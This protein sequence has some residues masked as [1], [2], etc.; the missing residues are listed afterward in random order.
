MKLKF[1]ISQKLI[2]GFGLILVVVL[3]NSILTIVTLVRSTNLNNQVTGIYGPTVNELGEMDMMITQSK[4]LIRNWVFVDKQPGTPDKIRLAELHRTDWPT[5]KQSLQPIAKKWESSE[6]LA[7]IENVF[8]QTD[9]LF[10]LHQY[11]MQNLSSFDS[12]EDVMVFFEAEDMVVEGGGIITLSDQIV[13]KLSQLTQKYSQKNERALDQMGSA[14]TTLGWVVIIMGILLVLASIAIGLVLYNSIVKP[15]TK[16]VEFAKA[17]GG[18]DLTAKVD[19]NQNDEIGMLAN[20]LSNMASNLKNIVMSIKESASNLVNSSDGLKTS[21]LQLSRGSADQAASAEEVSTSIEEMVANIDQ[22]TENSVQ[23]EKITV[24]TAKDV[25]VANELSSEAAKAMSAVSEKI[26]I[27]SDIAF[28]TNI[29]ALNAAVEAARAGEHGRG[30]SV[31][32][33]EVRKLAERSK[34]AADEIVTLVNRG[35]KVSKES[36]DKARG[37]VPDIEKTT[38]LVKEI[39]AA[40]ME[41]KTGADQINL[42]MQ[43]LNI[44][45]Q[46]NASSSDELTQSS[47]QL[48]VL[49]QNLQEA[50]SYFNIGDEPQTKKNRDDKPQKTAPKKEEKEG[51]KPVTSSGKYIQTDLSNLE[52]EFDLENYEKF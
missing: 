5:L 34:V 42:A 8:H 16:G 1:S 43:Q 52:K 36:G 23:T 28:Q 11:I 49:A 20:E 40:S 25:N 31:V 9:S 37:L 29:L 15:L 3:L 39:A 45:T 33:A 47:D 14:F 51:V 12:Y 6:D 38:L 10:E 21:S 35:L 26:S 13:D 32:A 27:I 2:Y 46:E 41:Q 4:M 24:E 7:L 18:G 44:I 17:I 30:F 19:I 22:N 50:V 48:F